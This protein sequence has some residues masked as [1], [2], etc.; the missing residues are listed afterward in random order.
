MVRVSATMTAVS[1]PTVESIQLLVPRG[2]NGPDSYA[3][4]TFVA[5]ELGFRHQLTQRVVIDAGIGTEF[6]RRSHCS[7]VP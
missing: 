4:R 7:P 3:A 2:A 1:V 6:C 5:S